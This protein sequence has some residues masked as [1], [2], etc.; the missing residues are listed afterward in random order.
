M[1]FTFDELL[2]KRAQREKDRLSVKEIRVPGTGR[3]L[4]FRKPGESK[5]LELF[6][7]LNDARGSSEEMIKAA[8]A[9]IYHCC[10]Q[11]QDTKLHTQLG[12]GDPLDVVPALFS[13]QERNLMGGELMQWLGLVGEPDEP[14][15]D[16][17]KN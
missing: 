15:E 10:E 2:A 13:V 11:L 12:I 17:V 4:L 5:M 3:G 6:G 14:E 8:D 9:A 7:M 16:A 1:Q